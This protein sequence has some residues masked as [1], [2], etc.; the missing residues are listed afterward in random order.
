MAEPRTAD[1]KYTMQYWWDWSIKVELERIACYEPFVRSNDLVFDIGANWG[2]KTWLFRQLGAK[3][4][5]VEPLLKWGAELI[6]EFNWKHKGD[7]LVIQVPKA[8]HDQ[9]GPAPI[10]IRK[11]LIYLS[12]M[13]E[14][15]MFNTVHKIFYGK[16]S[17]EK[18]MVE[19]IT[20]D[21]LINIYGVP[22]FIKIDVEGHEDHVVPTLTEPVQALNMEYHQDWIPEK[23][24]RHVDKLAQYEWAYTLNNECEYQTAWTDVDAVLATMR[25]RLEERGPRSWGDVYAR[26]VD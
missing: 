24:M 22:A 6:P 15:W 23:S 12:S 21:G 10:W 9:P 17:L 18:R 1:G 14:P 3:V 11:G 26:R 2:R 8:I 13:E 7:P 16:P 19:T 20:L 25:E 5:S 4:V